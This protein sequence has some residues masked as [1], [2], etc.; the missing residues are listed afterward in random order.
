MGNIHGGCINV[1]RLHRDGSTYRATPEPDFLTA[2]D[3]WFMPVVQKTGP[4][5]CLYILDWYDR[6]HCYQDANRD[7]QGIDR[8]K[9]RL[10]RVRYKN[11][12]RVGKFDLT[13]E[14]DEQL[15]KRLGHPNIYFRETAQR[16]L[17]ERDAPK[18][19][20]TLEL[21]VRDGQASH[22]ARRHALFALASCSDSSG[23][24]DYLLRHKEP[25]YR[26][27]GI[28]A[29]AN[30]AK[31]I[32]LI[33]HRIIATM[34]DDPSPDVA[35][36]AVVFVA[37]R[38]F[39]AN[40]FPLLHAVQSCGD[41]KLIPHIV[42]QN[43]HPM[44]ED[45][46]TAQY[47]VECMAGDGKPLSPGLQRM[48]PYLI[49]RLLAR[50]DKDPKPIAA[51]FALLADGKSANEEGARRCLDVVAQRVQ[52]G[53]IRGEA[54]EGLKQA[55]DATLNPIL[56]QP[57]SRLYLDAAFLAV[58]WKN[59]QAIDVVRG[60]FTSQGKQ[61]P[62]EQRLKALGALIAA[63]AELLEHD[64]DEAL[65][66]SK[67][68][69]EFRGQLLATM[70]RIN[71]LFVAQTVLAHY[72]SL[73]PANKPKAIELLTQRPAWAKRL[74][75]AIRNKQVPADA[76]NVNQV[77]RL[78]TTGD[79]ELASLVAKTWGTLRTERDPERELVVDRMRYVLRRT[80][81]D[82][83]RGWAVYDKLC[84]QCHKLHG[85]GQEVGPDITSN[86]R[87]SFEQLLSN[88]FD[89]SLVIGADYQARSVLTADGRTLTGLLV[90][91]SPQRIVLKTQG[92]KLETISRDDV[93][94]FAVSQL[95]MMPEGVE[96]Q[97]TAQELADLFA[98]LTLDKPPSEASAR[99]MPEVYD[100]SPQET[101]DAARFNR[102]LSEVAPGFSVK[103]SGDNGVA[104]L[105]EHR[106][107]KIVVRTHPVARNQPCLLSAK[108]PITKKGRPRLVVSVSHDS[109]G[110]WQLVVK[111]NGQKLHESLVSEKTTKSGWADISIDLAPF[112]GQEVLLELE[113]RSNDWSWEHAYWGGVEIVTEP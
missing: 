80:P 45:K 1:D 96:K 70:G 53:E 40:L 97:H 92:G 76:L 8:L 102:L 111:A 37:K 99:R 34:I 95:S 89:P 9:G 57:K 14:T 71:K 58:T 46:D 105:R 41:D 112:A 103:A 7:P 33:Y 6:Y 90:E 21:L 39:F 93:E 67:A 110:D 100:V 83:H 68:G 98:L 60:V 104:L 12:P 107:R 25:S 65:S 54:L 108:L 20:Q 55:L 81:G 75:E 69:E 17:T 47:F 32:D 22:K 50:R 29:A 109:R 2:N 88:T 91:D 86:G 101:K 51:L 35:L 106:G 11:T 10:Y 72:P 79:K 27:W 73:E 84:A 48:M 4:D 28:R 56:S 38:R 31:D 3:A 18:V 78:I 74:L 30:S 87:G 23:V 15:M 66:D 85:R 82:P 13:K 52:S 36:Q 44:L 43:V 16:L 63:D 61:Y 113:N 24:L 77:R 49:E 19:R 64:V 42:W 26:A 94:K 5:G 62:A 59:K